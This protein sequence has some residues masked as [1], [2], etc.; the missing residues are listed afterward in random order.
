MKTRLVILLIITTLTCKGQTFKEI[1]RGIRAEYQMT[2]SNRQLTKASIELSNKSTE[3][4]LLEL[5][6]DTEGNIRKLVATYHGESGKLIEEYYVKNN[7][8][9]FCLMRKFEYNRPIY[10]DKNKAKENNDHEVFNLRKSKIFESR[11]YF[12]SD[13]QLILFVD[14][15]K[16]NYQSKE[17]LKKP[18]T[19]TLKKFKTLIAIRK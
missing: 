8:L 11:Y 1:I 4:G 2:N 15:D 5:F 10:W 16:Q 9:F 12:N 17:Q 19:I 6:K 14:K 7:K 3:G 18:E 13:E